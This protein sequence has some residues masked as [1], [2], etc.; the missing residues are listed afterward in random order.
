MQLPTYDSQVLPKYFSW[1]DVDGQYLMS[2][3]H[4]KIRR[5]LSNKENMI[6][7]PVLA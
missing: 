4:V 7:F 5:M 2:L 6:N 3:I 1:Y